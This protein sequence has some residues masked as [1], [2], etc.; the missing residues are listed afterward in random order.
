MRRGLLR[1]DRRGFILFISIGFAVLLGMGSL[2]AVGNTIEEVKSAGIQ[3]RDKRAFFRADG[4]ANLCLRELRNRLQRDLDGSI[5]GLSSIGV[6]QPYVDNNDPAGLLAAYAYRAGVSYG[7]AFTR[8]NATTASLSASFAPGGAPGPYACSL[9]VVS[10]SAPANIGSAFAPIY[11]FRYRYAVTG[12]ASDGGR[13]HQVGLQGTFVVQVQQDNFARYALFTNRQENAAGSRVWF[14]NRTNFTGPVHTNGQFNFALNPG[15]S[16]TGKVTSVSSTARFYNGGSSVQLDADRNGSADVPTFGEGFERNVA[17]ISMPAT[18]T[19]DRQREAALGLSEGASVS[20]YG[21]GVHLG[22][23]GNSM[24]GGIYVNGNAS[25][26]M[27]AGANGP[28]YSI[29][30]GGT[31]TV[32]SVDTATNQ[33]SIRVGTGPTRSYDGVPNGMLYVDGE[34][35]GLA[36]TVEQGTQLTVAA[37]GDVKIT[38]NITYQS[39]TAGATPSAEGTA[40]LLGIMSWNGNVRVASTA[41]N[42]LNV[43]ATIMAPNGEFRVDNHDSGSPRGTATILGGVIE[44]TYGAFGTF[45]GENPS[46]GYGRNFVYDTR[47]GRGMAPP[48]F[49]TLGT[50]ISTL[51][52]VNDRPNW[53]SAN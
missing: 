19:R 14:T 41:P 8:V 39:Y 6:V 50:A 18:T 3:L 36:G 17:S 49:P 4:S 34:V 40:N 48:F 20:G 21:A 11:V 38:N 13:A 2:L 25:V 9:S 1:G 43:H 51:S 37:S 16:F 5:R 23:S 24:N 46:T 33:T 35:S 27:S 22:R 47:M 30:Q 32:V 7:P 12:S 29:V 26:Q 42:D 44:N 31:T 52:G 10:R 15:A 28:T 53:Q 45:S